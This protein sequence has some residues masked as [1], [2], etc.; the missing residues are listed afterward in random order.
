[1]IEEREKAIRR[2]IGIARAGDFVLI[3]GKGHERVQEFAGYEIEF[4]DREVAKRVLAE[5]L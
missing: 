2:A 1:M 3:A 5:S 4:D